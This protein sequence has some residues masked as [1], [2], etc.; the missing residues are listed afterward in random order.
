[1]SGETIVVSGKTSVVRKNSNH[2]N[3]ILNFS[4]EIEEAYPDFL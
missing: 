1:M 3:V 4:I 2:T